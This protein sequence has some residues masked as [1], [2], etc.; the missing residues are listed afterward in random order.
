MGRGGEGFFQVAAFNQFFKIRVE[1]APFLA[2][3]CIFF[4]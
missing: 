3:A 1:P 4:F 2:R